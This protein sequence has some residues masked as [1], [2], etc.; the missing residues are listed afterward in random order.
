MA[1]F[2]GDRKLLGRYV[3]DLE[4]DRIML[5]D[6]EIWSANPYSRYLF[7]FGDSGRSDTHILDEKTFTVIASGTA[8]F[9]AYR[10][11]ADFIGSENSVFAVTTYLSDRAAYSV[12]RDTLLMIELGT[13]YPRTRAEGGSRN[14]AFR[15]DFNTRKCI[16]LDPD[17]LMQTAEGPVL[18]SQGSE[19]GGDEDH[20]YVSDRSDT[21]YLE[22]IDAETLASLNAIIPHEKGFTA[23]DMAGTRRHIYALT[24]STTEGNTIY[25]IDPSTLL[26][27]KTI[28]A[29]GGKITIGDGG[30]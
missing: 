17:T 20:F 26:I 14:H 30:K 29:P 16:Q 2:I 5:G 9:T 7:V 19:G 3:G 4:I 24:V 10:D 25:E 11:D 12:D 27:S 28:T 13:E 22:Q 8:P 1:I 15:V 21:G 18:R 23:Y 6:T